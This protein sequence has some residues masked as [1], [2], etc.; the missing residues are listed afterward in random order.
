MAI[1]R[2]KYIS[3]GEVWF[4]EK[5]EK[6]PKV[7]VLYYLHQTQPIPN[8]QAR[9]FYTILIDLTKSNDDLW[10]NISKNDQYKIRRAG[11]K[12]QLKYTFWNSYD[13]NDEL[14]E[15]FSNFYD[16]FAVKKG[17]SAVKRSRLK[18]YAKSG[19]LDIS[20]IKLD[21]G[22]PLIWH[23]HY[24]CNNRAFLLHAASIVHDTDTSYNSML[25]RANRYHY[26][27]DMLRFKDLGIP[28]YDFGGWYAG[29]TDQKKLGIN[30]FKEKFGGEV[31]KNF[32]QSYGRTIKGQLYLQ[33]QKL[34]IKS[35]KNSE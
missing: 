18:S 8:I 11:Q 27:Q 2:G 16:V 32:S 19:V 34:F 31:V 5:T 28:I 3:I 24:R 22:E 13:I 10:E 12:D 9:E 4:D 20:H 29:N 7:D 23:A 33:L 14:I 15:E 17:L 6:I 35:P 26:W 1:V 21:N 25:G 30:K